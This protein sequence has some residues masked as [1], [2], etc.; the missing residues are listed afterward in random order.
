MNWKFIYPVRAQQ[1][2]P[3]IPY[4]DIVR[5]YQRDTAQGMVSQYLEDTVMLFSFAPVVLAN[6]P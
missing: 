4:V 2:L 3:S 1:P 5:H 6:T